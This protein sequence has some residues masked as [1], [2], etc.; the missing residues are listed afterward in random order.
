M[1]ICKCGENTFHKIF[2][3]NKTKPKYNNFNHV[4]VIS[5]STQQKTLAL[6]FKTKLFVR[7]I[8][9][10]SRD[11]SRR[12]QVFLKIGVLKNIAIFTGK[13]LY[14]GLFSIKLAASDL[15]IIPT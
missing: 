11:S 10:R 3:D 13:R 7:V 14:Q 2:F 6:V 9:Q 4:T 8:L 1:E 15:S 5:R 12:S